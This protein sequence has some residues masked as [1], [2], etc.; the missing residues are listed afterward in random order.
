MIGNGFVPDSKAT[1]VWLLA[2]E[3]QNVCTVR[4]LT[5][6][7]VHSQIACV[8]IWKLFLLMRNIE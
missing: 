1:L 6:Y 4:R 7:K 5:R 3:Y 2:N 8:I